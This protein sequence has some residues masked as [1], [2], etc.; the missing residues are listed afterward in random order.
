MAQT[1]VIFFDL[2]N[3]L[4]V[5]RLANGALVGIDVFPFV[6]DILASL[7]GRCR[8]GILSNTGSE[9]LQT[10]QSVL[11]AAGIAKFFDPSIELFSSVEGMDKTKIE[12]FRL[13]V[14]RASV[15]ASNCIYVSE[16]DAERTLAAK[17]GMQASFHPLHVFHVIKSFG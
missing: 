11:T 2:G 4:G 8:L 10:M 15:P 6:T 3:T 17:A 12:F 16:D 1:P 14:Q 9:S 5:A 7:R 13:A